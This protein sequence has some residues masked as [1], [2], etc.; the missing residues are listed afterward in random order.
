MKIGKRIN[1]VT[2]FRK[3][4]STLEARIFG[5]FL[6]Q[7]V[8]YPVGYDLSAKIFFLKGFCGLLQTKVHPYQ[9]FPEYNWPE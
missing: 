1:R 4:N 5:Y 8:P 6:R 9:N 2:G 3:E 7:A